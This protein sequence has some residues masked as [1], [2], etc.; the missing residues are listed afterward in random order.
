MSNVTFS[1]TAIESSTALDTASD[2]LDIIF[3]LDS[4]SNLFI[5]C[6]TVSSTVLASSKLSTISVVLKF[7]FATSLETWELLFS[8][9]S[10]KVALD[11][12]CSVVALLLNIDV[13]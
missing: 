4:W 13:L 12:P 6:F 7:F 11:I 3:F 10:E 8:T 9:N 2:L 1:L 5:Y